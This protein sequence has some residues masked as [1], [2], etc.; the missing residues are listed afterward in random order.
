MTSGLLAGSI[1]I[2][3]CAGIRLIK[4]NPLCGPFAL[5]SGQ[6]LSFRSSVKTVAWP[7]QKT[8]FASLSCVSLLP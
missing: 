4:D 1:E 8:D 5:P 3:A 2:L 7:S 6:N